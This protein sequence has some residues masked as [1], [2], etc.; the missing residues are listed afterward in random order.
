MVYSVLVASLATLAAASIDRLFAI[1]RLPRRYLWLSAIMI[2]AVA[3]VVAA[4]SNAPS[5][6][7]PPPLERPPA[8]TGSLPRSA[9]TVAPLQVPLTV[10]A[11]RVLRRADRPAQILWILT[12]TLTLGAFLGA[13]IVLRM[14]RASWKTATVDGHT[15]WI[16]PDVGPAVVGLMRPRIVL[17][18]WALQL[19]D[20]ERG[21]VLRHETEHIRAGDTRLLLVAGLLLVAMPWN[22]A[23]WWMTRRMRLAMEIDCDARVLCGMDAIHAYGMLLL[24]V[25]ERRGRNLPLV[26]SLTE[27]RALLERRIL[28]MTASRPSYPRLVSVALGLVACA[29]AIAVAQTPVPRGTDGRGVS[30]AGSGETPHEIAQQTHELVQKLVTDYYPTV[31][32]GESL[33][34]RITFVLDADGNYVTSAAWTD[35]AMLRRSAAATTTPGGGAAFAQ[36]GVAKRAFESVRV[37]LGAGVGGGGGGRVAPTGTGVHDFA[38]FGF[39]NIASDAVMTTQSASSLVPTALSVFIIRLKK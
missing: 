35:T 16:A 23:L 9:V 24:A 19:G 18:E 4:T 20:T 26:A 3:P 17:P 2:A 8:R 39:P 5:R 27:Q 14:R 25:D 31:M 15:T 7:T 30:V 34:N 21:F 36:S 10:R 6:L 37:V 29:A 13:F 33:I 12:S 22:P 11:M 28:A 1:W 32:E 38:A